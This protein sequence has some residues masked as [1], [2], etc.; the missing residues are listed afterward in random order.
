[1]ELTIIFDHKSQA[2]LNV[3]RQNT[4][5]IELLGIAILPSIL[6]VDGLVVKPFL[7]GVAP[8]WVRI[9]VDFLRREFLQLT[10][11]TRLLLY[12][13]MQNNY[14][15]LSS[16]NRLTP[17]PIYGRQNN[18]MQIATRKEVLPFLRF[19]LVRRSSHEGLHSGQKG[20]H[21]AHRQH[22]LQAPVVQV[23]LC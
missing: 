2:C 1:M 15:T 19:H 22:S 4:T 8:L 5:F 16:L 7:F 13:R 17:R 6:G 18:S 21:E 9:S 10:N 14:Q 12:S 23:H 3:F 20:A 11:I